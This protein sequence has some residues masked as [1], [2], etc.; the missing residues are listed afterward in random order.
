MVIV[1]RIIAKGFKSFANKTELMFGKG[2]NC[3]IG[4]NGSGKCLK[5]N[6]IITLSNGSEI[7]IG[8]LVESKLKNSNNIKNVNEG[9]YCDGDN[10]SIVS[11]NPK[12]LKEENIIISKFVKREGEEL[13]YIKTRTG[14][15]LSGTKS[16]PIMIFK[17]GILK[18]IN[19]EDLKKYDVIATPRTLNIKGKNNFDKDK[20]RL[21]GYIIGDGYIGKDR[22]DFTNKDKEL[23]EDYTN[24]CKKFGVNN[25]KHS[26][27]K[28]NNAET[29]YTR[30]KNL[31]NYIRELFYKNFK[32]SIIGDIKNI[33]SIF[34]NSNND[35]ISELIGGIFDTDGFV[36]KELATL[37]LCS[38][39]KELI[40]QV[41]RL[42]LRFGIISI[43][44]KRIKFATNTEAKIKRPYYSLY[45]YGIENVKKFYINIKLKCN[46]KRERL[47]KIVSKDIKINNNLDLL[48]EETNYYIKELAKLLGLN[49]K[50]LKK[51]YPR[52]GA[53]YENRCLPTREGVNE[54]LYLF[55]E[56]LFILT[57]NLKNIKFEQ[58]NLI[59]CLDNLNISGTSASRSI[60]LS[61]QIIRDHWATNK[62]TAKEKN[63]KEFYGFIRTNLT[64]RFLK[65]KKHL[66]VLNNIVNSDI[67]WDEII[68][69]RKTEKEAYVYDLTIP[70]N[71]NFI[72][73]GIFVHNS[74]IV[75][76]MCF[77]L[78]KS[79]AKD[80]RAE[81][82]ANLIYNGGK[83]H[84]PA[85]EAEVTIEFDNS[86]KTFI[87]D[88]KEIAI[89]RIVRH[90]GN[91][92]YKI[93]DEVRTRQ[94][95]L[96]LLRASKLDPDGHNI[97]LQ[98]D[99][100]GFMEMKPSDRRLIIEEI[101]GISLY[102]EKKNK[103]LLE[104][105]KV[106]NSLNEAG[107][108]L[109]EREANLRELK[110]ERDQATKYKQLQDEIKDHRA[111]Y[112]NFQIKN[113]QEKVNEM[114]SRKKEAEEKITKINS[115]IN[116]IKKQVLDY[117]Q[118]I[119]NINNEIEVKGEKEQIILRKEIEDI[120]TN[121][122]KCNS[123]IEVC[124]NQITQIKTRKEQ[125]NNNIK[126]LDEKIKELNNNIKDNENK[127]KNLNSE[128]VSTNNKILQFKEKHGIDS[129]FSN[130]L[131]SFD[132][133]ID[134]LNE[135]L[136]KINEEKQNILRSKDQ[137]VFRLGSIN[138]KIDNMK[139]SSADLE[140]LKNK[141]KLFK[142]ITEKLSKCLNEDSS[143][144]SQLS[145]YR[146]DLNQKSEEFAKLR[147]RQIS[148]QE[149]TFGDLAI[150]KIIELK[151]SLNGIHGTVSELGKVESKYS[152]ALEVAAGPR[153]QSIVVDSEIT[154]EKC[155]EHL[156]T[157]KLGIAI[158]LPLNKIKAKSTDLTIKSLINSPG[159]HGFAT[160]IVKYDKKYEDI[161]HYVLGP[162]LIIDNVSTGRRIG[163]GRTRMV[164]MDGDIMESSGAMI[165]GYRHQKAGFGFKEKE[166]EENLAKLE[167][168]IQKLKSL[169]NH[170]DHKKTENE[171]NLV[172]LRE[173]KAN[174]EA[175]IITV[176]K[177][178]NISGVDITSLM[179]E[180]KELDEKIKKS[181][182]ELDNF[183]NK[184]KDIQN[185]I[186][187][188]KEKR[189][190]LKEKLNNPE[191]ART[192]ESLEQQRLKIRDSII[193]INN[194]IK[195]IDLQ[196]STIL[197]VEKDK[198]FKIIKQHDKE[199]EDF[200]RE[201]SE[202][203]ESLKL[204][205]Q[206]FKNKE[207]EESK[208][209]NTFKDLIIKRNKLN[210]KIQ[211][212]ETNIAREEEK[213]KSFEQK[214]NNISIDRAKE[215]A[216]FEGLQKEFEPFK[217]STIKRGL[218]LEDI[219]IKINEFEKELNKIGNVNLRALEVYESIEKEYNIIVEKV[220]KL[221][222]EKDDVLKMMAEIDTKKKDIFMKTYNKIIKTFKEIYSQLT[223]KG[224]AQV[225]LENEDN[226]F[227]GGIDIQI[228]IAGTKCLDIKALSGGE[229][230]M[231]ALSFIF[232][233]QE[234][235]DRKSVV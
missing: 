128:E 188:S 62:F 142:D 223:T 183:L 79:S 33:P 123:R 129:E 203:K 13:Y 184:I 38:K 176:E 76:A 27:K 140:S 105:Q 164:T 122:I 30:D 175:E 85:K 6:T 221:K 232:A 181:E 234:H 208:F 81:K 193:V 136:V 228:K 88:S 132:R 165:G 74:N 195:N 133:E 170:V 97:I 3:V 48:P 218:S 46:H 174:L 60:N 99:I 194:A 198:T 118:Q 227:E 154:A 147:S 20:A 177:T 116:D 191:I 26:D 64:F 135:N 94:Q 151:N 162:T 180:R 89:T 126:E 201:L 111:T 178:L 215:I 226:P 172:N 233:I 202:L 106:D 211:F 41:Q 113:K 68:E 161:F 65:I 32:K 199:N 204:K 179:S 100:I 182:K 54:I 59:G 187:E 5:Y 137:L 125:L 52:L 197:E 39:N 209:H 214:L 98:G 196:I 117:K 96:D 70:G 190:K 47:E 10:T 229:K 101:S 200:L 83:K 37:E 121:I 120:K 220:E 206:S 35:I 82:S 210:E 95:V 224:E 24:I 42:L 58:N 7:K 149:R 231:T 16:H 235:S 189:Q 213:L 143:Y 114:E 12:T 77:V 15:E 119:N 25:I 63:I 166:T 19:L 148:I 138:E 134:K 55:K 18:T 217:E 160:D 127:L 22:I 163:I 67:L 91:S 34:F 207:I 23:L 157:N 186:E 112:I 69:V 28:D 219:K 29:L 80:M 108:I 167:E 9:I 43:I 130:I 131:E 21:I 45:I 168:E 51:Q 225:I 205:E 102:E 110:K 1:K 87:I 212:L 115:I 90:N 71:H 141:K 53:Y 103:C 36:A 109:T 66:S 75:D 158:F 150:R 8:D 185:N 139:G 145:N 44:N 192:L 4:P 230:T 144:A 17:N 173:Q 222:T 93:N 49:I 72:A 57:N 159:V 50:N 124:Q 153:A 156:K 216:E 84:S 78:G 31:V 14:K 107:I 86:D 104:L 152:L 155:I 61:K 73:N 146:Y 169:V 11:I 171:I 2:F 92:I 56:K 40:Y